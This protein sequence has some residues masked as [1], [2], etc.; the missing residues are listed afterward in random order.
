M[1]NEQQ[2]EIDKDYSAIKD[3]VTTIIT[4]FLIDFV[5][6]NTLAW[7]FRMGGATK[8]MAEWKATM[9]KLSLYFIVIL[10]INY[11]LFSYWYINGFN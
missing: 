8:E 10:W 2:S 1:K 4:L 6:Q 11:E 3:T 7:L 5:L 9:V